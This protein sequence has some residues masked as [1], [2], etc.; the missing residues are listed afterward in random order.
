MGILVLVV[1]GYFS[2]NDGGIS[3]NNE[4]TSP[5]YPLPP[6]LRPQGGTSQPEESKDL[7]SPPSSFRA[8]PQPSDN[9][10]TQ[11]Y[12]RSETD[13]CKAWASAYPA[14]ASKLKSTDRCFGQF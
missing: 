10:E 1:I 9:S 13:G 2:E 7:F 12:S 5:G 14:L 4:N 6:A 3:P 8:D 11:V